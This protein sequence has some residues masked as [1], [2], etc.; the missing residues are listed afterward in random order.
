MG[1]DHRSAAPACRRPQFDRGGGQ[2]AQRL[3]L[4]GRGRQH[5][6]TAARRNRQRDRR[7]LP[8][9][10]LPLVCVSPRSAAHRALPLTALCLSFTR[11]SPAP[12]RHSPSS[13]CAPCV[14][15]TLT[16]VLLAR[17]RVDD[18]ALGHDQEHGRRSRGRL[19]VLHG[20]PCAPCADGREA[21]GTRAGKVK[22]A[23]Q[24]PRTPNAIRPDACVSTD[25][26]L[27][28][29]RQE[30]MFKVRDSN[31]ALA[32]KMIGLK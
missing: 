26:V 13:L 15:R 29:P 21:H 19:Q 31:G 12:A 3:P 5:G 18:A 24:G 22:P 2:L 20:A 32:N 17:P 4:D 6:G 23:S 1:L 8:L 25:S 30:V 10:V 14:P 16:N 11:G 7:A 28:Q 27:P 9:G